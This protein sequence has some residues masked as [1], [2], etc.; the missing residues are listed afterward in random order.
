[1]LDNL[2]DG[3][4]LAL[5]DVAGLGLADADLRDARAQGITMS[6]IGFKV[7]IRSG[8][9]IDRLRHAANTMLDGL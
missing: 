6:Y 2:S 9:D 7:Q 3:F 4:A 8:A 5:K 1:M